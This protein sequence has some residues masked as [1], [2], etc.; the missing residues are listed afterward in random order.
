M[1][2]DVSKLR[3]VACSPASVTLTHID[4]TRCDRANADALSSVV[5]R[6]H[7]LVRLVLTACAGVTDTDLRSL[8]AAAPESLSLER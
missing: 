4:L 1:S 7:G 3:D 8:S 2:V 6:C 5:A